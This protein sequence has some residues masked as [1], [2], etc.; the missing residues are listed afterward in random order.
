MIFLKKK[1][2]NKIYLIF[3]SSFFIFF[4]LSF[5][6]SNKESITFWQAV[7]ITKYIKMFTCWTIFIL[8]DS[9]NMRL[10]WKVSWYTCHLIIILNS[11]GQSSVQSNY[12]RTIKF[13]LL[14]RL[15]N[16]TIIDWPVFIVLI[17]LSQFSYQLFFH[18][19]LKSFLIVGWFYS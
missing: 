13:Y 15:T 7:K 3:N 1:S 2:V 4:S 9:L 12:I 11:S 10:N 17:K 16:E 5:Y 14:N 19:A 18:F 6:L 8:F